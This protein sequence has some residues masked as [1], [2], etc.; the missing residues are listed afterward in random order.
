LLEPDPNSKIY[1]T[2]SAPKARLRWDRRGILADH[3]SG[4]A[5]LKYG[6]T[7]ILPPVGATSKH[8]A[9]LCRPGRQAN[10]AHLRGKPEF[11]TL[12]TGCG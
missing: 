9:R 3:I 8:P 5:V 1:R 2:L 6:P 4:T 7:E 10:R 11:S 12:E